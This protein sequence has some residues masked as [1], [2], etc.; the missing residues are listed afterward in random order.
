MIGRSEGN[1]FFSM[2]TESILKVVSDIMFQGTN[3]SDFAI[4]QARKDIEAREAAV[5]SRELSSG[6][7]N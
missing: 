5:A 3:I 7:R 6:K 4:K 2:Q 1:L